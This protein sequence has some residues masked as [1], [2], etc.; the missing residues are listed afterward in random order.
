M[1]ILNSNGLKFK[2]IENLKCLKF[3]ENCKFCNKKFLNYKITK[4][5]YPVLVLA[6]YCSKTKK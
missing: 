1:N 2:K 3:F 4:N 6:M 5:Y